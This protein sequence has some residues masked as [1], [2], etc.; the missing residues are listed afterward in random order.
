[1][2]E[3]NGSMRGEPNI[4]PCFLPWD[5]CWSVFNA[6]LE[7]ASFVESAKRSRREVEFW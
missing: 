7:V 3:E 1:M 4:L 2:T 6:G 5:T